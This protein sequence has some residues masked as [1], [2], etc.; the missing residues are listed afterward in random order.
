MINN[1]FEVANIFNESY[2]K[3]I[4][5]TCGKPPEIL[6]SPGNPVQGRETIE[7]IIQHIK[8]HP[9]IK[10]VN[11]YYSTKEPFKLFTPAETSTENIIINWWDH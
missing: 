5:E 7:H 1:D 8:E 10:E 9:S 11:K 4:E 3:I 6:D 2:M